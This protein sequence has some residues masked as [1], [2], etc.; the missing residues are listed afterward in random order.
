[1][2]EALEAVRQWRERGSKVALATVVATRRSAPRPLGSKLAVSEAGEL[3]G[4]VSGGCVESDVAMHAREVLETGQPKLVSYGIPDEDAWEVGLPCGGEID[5]FLERVEDE[6]P[7]PGRPQVVFTV[8]EGDRAGERWASEDGEVTQTQLLER[9]GERIFA[10]VL[11]PPPR[12]LVFGAVDLAEE[13][14][15]AAKGLGWRTI[16]ADARARFA[17]PD[18]IPSADELA[19][20]WP[21]ETLERF[22]PDDRTAVIVLTHEDRW[23]VPALAGALASEAFYVGALGSRRTQERRREQL[24]ETG[25]SDEQLERLCGPAGLDLGAATPAETALSIL[26]EIL[27]VRAGREG[28]RLRASSAR[29]HA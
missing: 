3:A 21:E 29:I 11:G 28:G 12:L 26:A 17:T 10:E 15:R 4:S 6:L 13:L 20:A 7:D 24:L 25:V 1:M 16:V 14:C 9:E 19:V 18:R 22:E 27:A 2:R 5:V 8:V 23:D